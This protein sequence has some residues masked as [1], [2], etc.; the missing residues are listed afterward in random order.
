MDNRYSCEVIQDLIPG[1]ID[2]VLSETGTKVV[3]E[4][5]EDCSECQ[6]VYQE[7]KEGEKRVTAREQIV[8]DG[9][10]KIRRRTKILKLI[11]GIF[12]SLCL[13]GVGYVLLIWYVIGEPVVTSQIVVSEVIYQE[14]DQSLTV[15]GELCNP[16]YRVSRV[17]WEEDEHTGGEVNIVVYMA[18]K[19][20]F[21]HGRSD[22]T[23]TIPN[24]EDASAYLACP[25][26]D[27]QEIY[28]WSQDHFLELYALEEKIYD[29]VPELDRERDVMMFSGIWEREGK[30]WATYSVDHLFGE[31]VWHQYFNGQLIM[32][33]DIKLGDFKMWI[34]WEEPYEILVYDCQTF[35]YKKDTSVVSEYIEALE[36]KE[37]FMSE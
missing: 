32:H 35:E 36:E 4:H 23:V 10:R 14:K 13:A 20:P 2:Q 6:K 3:Q 26:Y 25:K 1:Y 12:F 9:F 21:Y 15:K 17:V 24:M 19:L 29:S 18:E 27:R 22:F 37:I 31:D 33:G 28:N 34:T 11:A 16:S 8:L 7:M 5:L 30:K